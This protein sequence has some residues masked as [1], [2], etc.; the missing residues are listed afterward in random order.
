MIRNFIDKNKLAIIGAATGAVT[1]WLYWSLIGCETG[2]CA[3]TSKPLNS[4]VYGA[5]LGSLLFSM[6]RRA[7]KPESK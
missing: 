4:T 3:I 5:V 7:D 2:A 1:G 6:F